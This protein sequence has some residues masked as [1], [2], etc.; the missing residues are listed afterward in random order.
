MVKG[1]LFV[2]FW[3]YLYN[4]KFYF[5]VDGFNFMSKEYIYFLTALLLC[6]CVVLLIYIQRKF[7]QMKAI[8]REEELQKKRVAE[9]YK[10]QRAYLIESIGVI[11]KAYGSDERLSC[12]E[13]CMRLSTLLSA[14][15]PTL[16]DKPELSV[17][18]EVHRKTEHIPVKDKWKAL[19]KQERW[20]F[21]KEMA[22]VESEHETDVIAAAAYLTTYDFDLMVH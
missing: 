4:D 2:Q 6:V 3:R 17:I 7:K 22:K 16:L 12:T 11:A 10:E 18:R 9:R 14:L 20:G 21:S 5:T 1:E 8:K 19:S 15:S 13:A